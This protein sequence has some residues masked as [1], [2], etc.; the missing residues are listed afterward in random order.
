MTKTEIK[1]QEFITVDDF[2]N[3]NYDRLSIEDREFL[4]GV[5]QQLVQEIINS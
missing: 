3:D 2:L 1:F 4:V 5:L